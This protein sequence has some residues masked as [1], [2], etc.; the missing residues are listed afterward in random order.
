MLSR[1][2]QPKNP[3]PPIGRQRFE[4]MIEYVGRRNHS[5]QGTSKC[6]GRRIGRNISFQYK[7]M[8]IKHPADFRRSRAELSLATQFAAEAVQYLF[9]WAKTHQ[10]LVLCVDDRF[11]G[12]A[13]D[14]LSTK[15]LRSCLNPQENRPF[16]LS[17]SQYVKQPKA[18]LKGA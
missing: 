11:I 1:F 18:N 7:E 10:P 3:K 5:S 8:T 17:D 13:K 16:L 6:D 12:S 4:E 9:C 15:C 2:F 14:T